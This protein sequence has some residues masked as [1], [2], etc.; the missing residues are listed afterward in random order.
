[1]SGLS[2]AAAACVIVAIC[3]TYS[4]EGADAQPTTLHDSDGTLAFNV[5]FVA[6][7]SLAGLMTL[8][9][10]TARLGLGLAVGAGLVLPGL[11]VAG[12]VDMFR[13]GPSGASDY[14]APGAGFYW[15]T[16]SAGL[17]IAAAVSAV[18][19]LRRGGDFRLAPIKASALWAALGLL[20]AA[21]WLVGT[22]LPWQK[23]ELAF[24][25]TGGQPQTITYGPCCSLSNMPAQWAIQAIAIAV[26]IMVACLI[27]ACLRSAAITTGILLAACVCSASSVLSTLW[28]KPYTLAQ[29][30]PGL[31]VSEYQLTQVKAVVSLHRLPGVWI[32]SAAVLGLLLLAVVRGL[33]AAATAPQATRTEEASADA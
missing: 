30:A 25:P 1:M 33:H 18:L 17:A 7:L 8:P 10:T 20:C 6:L 27:A 3:T 11:F 4:F 24:T 28:S 2:I 14:V 13:S 16:V 15:G 9:R 21:A 26:L 29:L 31:E 5:V 32:T 23:Q 19:G 22:W 12:T